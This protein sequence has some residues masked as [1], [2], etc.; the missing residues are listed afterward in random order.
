MR[1]LKLE[2]GGEKGIFVLGPLLPDLSI[3]LLDSFLIK[4]GLLGVLF[5]QYIKEMTGI[6]KL[7]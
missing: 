3:R 1:S 2:V 7:Y 5:I 4:I 6:L